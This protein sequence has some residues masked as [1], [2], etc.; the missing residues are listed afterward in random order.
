M[1]LRCSVLLIGSETKQLYICVT[2]AGVTHRPGRA[3]ANKSQ[4]NWLEE[5]EEVEEDLEQQ[6]ALQ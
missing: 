2:G 3:A 5:E 6:E 1:F 4:T